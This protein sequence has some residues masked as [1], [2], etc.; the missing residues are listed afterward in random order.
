MMHSGISYLQDHETIRQFPYLLE[1]WVTG[2]MTPGLGGHNFEMS[3]HPQGQYVDTEAASQPGGSPKIEST[4]PSCHPVTPC[5]S[6]DP[7]PF[8]YEEF[9]VGLNNFIAPINLTRHRASIRVIV[10]SRGQDVQD[11]RPCPCPLLP[12]MS[13]DP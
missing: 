12:S 6:P 7:Y 8:T 2:G 13:F 1:Y 9:L 10:M 11:G 4:R 3:Y 5:T